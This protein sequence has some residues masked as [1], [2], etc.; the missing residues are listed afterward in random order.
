MSKLSGRSWLHRTEPY[1]VR[2]AKIDDDGTHILTTDKGELRLTSSQVAELLPV[3]DEQEGAPT[4]PAATHN[5]ALNFTSEDATDIRELSAIVMASIRK[6]TS[7]A[8]YID[9]AKAINEGAKVL[10][11]IKRLVIDAVRVVRG[12]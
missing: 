4:L 9:Q 10:V 11:D 5:L 7:D 1:Y 12:S 2:S 3:E 8:T 6:V